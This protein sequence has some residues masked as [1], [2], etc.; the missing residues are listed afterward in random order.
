MLGPP[1]GLHWILARE[2][3]IV[4]PSPPVT[5]PGGLSRNI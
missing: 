3:A 2:L 4:D 5:R 1:I